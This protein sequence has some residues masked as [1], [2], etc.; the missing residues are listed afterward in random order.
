[1][2]WSLPI[3]FVGYVGGTVY[4]ATRSHPL[5]LIMDFMPIIILVVMISVFFW[6]RIFA[7]YWKIALSIV[8]LIFLPRMLLL[9]LFDRASEMISL[10]YLFMGLPIIAPILIH[11]YRHQ[12]RDMLWAGVSFMTLFAAVMF[13]MSDTQPSVVEVFPMGTHWLWHLFG[14]LT[15]HIIISYLYMSEKSLYNLKA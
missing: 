1:M 8:G 12:W 5:W 15:C 10:G 2:K 9:A 4:H 6:K 14:G 11:E 13:R 3:L 7:E